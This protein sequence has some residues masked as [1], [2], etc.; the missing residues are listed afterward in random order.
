MA[1]SGINPG[2]DGTVVLNLRHV[3]DSAV[4]M[5]DAADP[6]G[7]TAAIHG[8][9]RLSEIT[10]TLTDQGMLST[11]A[12]VKISNIHRAC[13]KHIH[14]LSGQEESVKKRLAQLR[15][16]Q[17]LTEQIKSPHTD[18]AEE[19]MAKIRR[20]E[21]IY[22][23]I[24]TQPSGMDEDDLD[25]LIWYKLHEAIDP[26]SSRGEVDRTSITLQDYVRAW[27]ALQRNPEDLLNM[28]RFK[29]LIAALPNEILVPAFFG[30]GIDQ[31]C[32]FTMAGVGHGDSPIVTKITGDH[33]PTVKEL[34]EWLAVPAYGS[35]LY[36]D[37]DSD[38]EGFEATNDRGWPIYSRIPSSE[39]RNSAM[40]EIFKDMWIKMPK[41]MTEG[42]GT[43]LVVS[44]HDPQVM[45][46]L[47]MD[48]DEVI[49]VQRAIMNGNAEIE[50]V[51]MIGVMV[52]D[53]PDEIKKI[54]TMTETKRSTQ[55]ANDL[56][57]WQ[58]LPCK[59]LPQGLVAVR[60]GTTERPI[61]GIDQNRVM[62]VKDKLVWFKEGV[63]H[64]Q[65]DEKIF[66]SP[67]VKAVLAT[68]RIG[69]VE[70]PSEISRIME[71][72]KCHPIAQMKD[73]VQAVANMAI[74]HNMTTITRLTTQ[75]FADQVVAPTAHQ[76][77]RIGPVVPVLLKQV[78]IHVVLAAI[79][80]KKDY[81]IF[82]KIKK[83]EKRGPTC[84]VRA[85]G[86]P[87]TSLAAPTIKVVPLAEPN[88]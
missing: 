18:H 11:R 25:D 40:P 51:F 74:V 20:I 30:L 68:A 39:K 37:I 46:L 27:S 17:T 21:A 45:A 55:Q 78:P 57:A 84:P 28:A 33:G 76:W 36:P 65:I 66:Y 13:T 42:D 47:D 49:E 69:T 72:S 22:A 8:A 2:S 4:Q 14:L 16:V 38:A 29:Q 52:D 10:E 35:W 83:V 3:Q 58:A 75:T 70:P 32:K 87:F 71:T 48:Q 44:L 67:R 23:G 31:S 1:A 53:Y 50:T 5:D 88:I 19:N 12:Q 79:E 73:H 15:E 81:P 24:F 64:S 63:Y 60:A 85:V 26:S 80:E 61:Q 82:S 34:A 62:P 6:D 9:M 41:D 54:K 77:P 59:G 56:R 86:Y 43:V 7:T